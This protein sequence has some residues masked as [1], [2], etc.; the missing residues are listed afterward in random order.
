[1]TPP[2]RDISVT[3]PVGQAIDRM[4]QLLFQPFDLRKWFVIGFCA[5]LAHLGESGFRANY[6]LGSRNKTSGSGREVFERARDYVMSNLSW[7]IPL[8]VGAILLG[9]ALWVLFIWLSSRGRFMFLHCVAFDRAEV[10]APW[11][12]YAREANSLF[13]FRLVLSVVAMII[14]LPLAALVGF[15]VFRMVR[16]GSPSAPGL[17]IAIGS[18]LAVIAAAIVFALIE[19]LTTDFVVPI[20]SL[21]GKTC[22]LA[23]AELRTLLSDNLGNL[24]LYL[25]FQILLAIVIGVTLLFVILV[26]C[27]IA[28]CLFSLPYLGTVLL[29]PV[30]C[31]SRA[32]SLHYL[33]QFGSQ[34]DVFAPP[35]GSHPPAPGQ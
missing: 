5:W 20:M 8:A 22:R 6:N 31:F 10:E 7:I 19:K 28:G 25:L 27:C 34:Y 1:M 21:R 29:L 18:G 23:W 11:R 14:I 4:R 13:W 32:Y 26:T 9:L 17:A 24:I 30:F 2:Y 15:A 33:A 16:A 12:R 35:V 3:T